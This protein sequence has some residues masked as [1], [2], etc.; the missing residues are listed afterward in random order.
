MSLAPMYST[1]LSRPVVWLLCST[2]LNRSHILCSGLYRIWTMVV[3]THTL[4]LSHSQMHFCALCVSRTF[5]QQSFDICLSVQHTCLHPI[6]H[7]VFDDFLLSNCIQNCARNVHLL[8]QFLNPNQR[9]TDTFGLFAIGLAS[10][11]A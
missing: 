10:H 5:L 7:S 8:V 6:I 3:Y 4:F 11:D 1:R 2:L 9:E